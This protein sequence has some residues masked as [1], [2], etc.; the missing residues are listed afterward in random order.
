MGS[1]GAVVRQQPRLLDQG[2]IE[3]SCER[4]GE[5]IVSR[6]KLYLLHQFV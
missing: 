4:G 2:E 6:N 1:R 5:I 3:L